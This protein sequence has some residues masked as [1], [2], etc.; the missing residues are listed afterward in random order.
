M[1]A[2]PLC[3]NESSST[4]MAADARKNRDGIELRKCRACDFVYS[5]KDEYSYGELFNDAFVDKSKEDLVRIA[6][7]QGLDNLVAEIARKAGIGKD[8][9]ILDFGS[10]IGLM[11]LMFQRLGF[12]AFAVEGSR[13]Y[14]EKHESLG[15]KSFRSIEEAMS[16]HKSF[17]LVVI[18]DVLEHLSDPKRV[19]GELIACVKPG[20]YFYI[21][22]PNVH[23]YRFHWSIDTQGHINHFTPKILIRLFEEEKMEKVDFV[24]VYDIRSLAGKL[25]HSIFWA[26][27]KL[28]PLYHQISLLFRRQ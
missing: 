8:A 11:I 14:I 17:D 6:K 16:D 3:G 24:G 4:Y 15:I 18:K 21:R 22:V 10:G 2:C 25:Y 5:A 19:L 20:G 13:K 28:F 27:R 23:A 12:D 26:T 7:S 1:R 9:K